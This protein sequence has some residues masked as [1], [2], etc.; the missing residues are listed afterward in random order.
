MSHQEDR[1]DGPQSLRGEITRFGKHH[2][3]KYHRHYLH[4]QLC[5]Y[6][7]GSM[8]NQTIILVSD[9]AIFM[10]LLHHF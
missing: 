6:P 8:P 1:E 4:C 7:I 5:L 2:N 10:P 3:V 9:S